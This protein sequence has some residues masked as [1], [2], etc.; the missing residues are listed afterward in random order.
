MPKFCLERNKMNILNLYPG[1]WGSNCYLLSVGTHALIVDPSANAQTILSATEQ[2]GA[3]LEGI[4]LTHA[5]FDHI[6]SVNGIRDQINI[7]LY[8]HEDDAELITDA[9]K[10]AFYTF[11]RMET[12]YRPADKLLRVGD[13]LS[14]GNE[15][16]KVLHTPG[17][18]AGSV[19]YLCNGEF[20]LTGDTLFADKIGRCDLYGSDPRAMQR[21]LQ[22]LRTLPPQL[23][24]YPGHGERARLGTALD[25]V[26]YF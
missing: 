3:T 13:T 23:K 17:H 7:P 24:I 6:V 16:I 9:H 11:F 21:S 4:L 8:V 5:H 12:D 14:L 1:S 10:N 2:I 20:L 26:S 18:S 19:C 22:F 15:M 25:T